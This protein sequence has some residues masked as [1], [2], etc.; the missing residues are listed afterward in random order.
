MQPSWRKVLEL[1]IIGMLFIPIVAVLN[2]A[3]I[4]S[5]KNISLF[6]G[7]L[8]FYIYLFFGDGYVTDVY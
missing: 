4:F 1:L 5:F 3:P 2:N 6:L 7:I 8:T